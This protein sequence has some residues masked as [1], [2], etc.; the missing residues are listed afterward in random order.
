MPSQTVATQQDELLGRGQRRVAL[1]RQVLEQ[2]QPAAL[3]VQQQ[4]PALEEVWE[5]LAGWERLLASAQEAA[6]AQAR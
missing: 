4:P 2:E 3:W 5:V 6:L 1:Q